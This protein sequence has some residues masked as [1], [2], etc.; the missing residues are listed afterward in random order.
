MVQ[1]TVIKATVI[2]ATVQEVD[3]MKDTV[4]VAM[5]SQKSAVDKIND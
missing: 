1:V 4:Q 3:I 5:V 2:K